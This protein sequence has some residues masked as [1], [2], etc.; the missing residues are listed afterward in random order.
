MS[1][2]EEAG[3]AQEPTVIAT[4]HIELSPSCG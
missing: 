1:S 4:A 3:G 2:V